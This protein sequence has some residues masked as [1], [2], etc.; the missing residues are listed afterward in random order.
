MPTFHFAQLGDG[1]WIKLRE[2][3]SALQAQAYES[4]AERG[5]GGALQTPNP[6]RLDTECF[7]LALVGI[8]DKKPLL[9]QVDGKPVQKVDR[10]GQPVFRDPDKKRPVFERFDPETLTAA[11][12]KPLTYSQ[13]E[14]D[15]DLMFG[16]KDRFIIG[17][18][19][20]RAHNPGDEERDF[21][22]TIHSVSES[23]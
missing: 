10:D 9:K 4:A 16:P 7:R 15:F 12:W 6:V 21:F 2:L 18:L 5:P 23:G 20:A 22:E 8:T 1:R 13:L 3:S 19:Y 14:T 11:D 17:A